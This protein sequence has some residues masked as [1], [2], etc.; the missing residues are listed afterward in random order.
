M[1][2]VAGNDTTHLTEAGADAVA[3]IVIEGI[4]T[5]TNVLKNFVK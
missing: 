3:E 2:N 4:K 5:N 1:F